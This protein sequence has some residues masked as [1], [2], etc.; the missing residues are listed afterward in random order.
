MPQVLTRLRSRHSAAST[1]SG[2]KASVRTPTIMVAADATWACTPPIRDAVD[3]T[4]AAGSKQQLVSQPPGH[5]PFGHHIGH[6]DH[7]SMAD[8]VTT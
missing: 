7:L 3:T 2:T 5:C 6:G 4:S 1:S 8:H